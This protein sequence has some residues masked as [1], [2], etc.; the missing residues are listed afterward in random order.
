MMF[1]SSVIYVSM[2]IK[3]LAYTA[4]VYQITDVEIVAEGQ[5]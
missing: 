4:I 2:W 5:N 3:D 1:S